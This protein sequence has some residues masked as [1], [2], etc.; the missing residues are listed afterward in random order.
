MKRHPALVPLSRQHHDALAVGVF[1]QRGLRDGAGPRTAERLR[2]QALDV[3]NLELSGHFEVEETVLFPVARE[4]VSQPETVD[5]LLREHDGI[6]EAFSA[7][8][9]AG[10]GELESRLRVLRE[11]LV[12]HIRFEE[13][14]VFEALQD[15]MAEQDLAELGLQIDAAL[16]RLCVRLGSA[17]AAPRAGR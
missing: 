13:R 7:L 10:S 16:P 4:A 5:R 11:R 3:W 6:R 14:V 2:R 15:S 1:I 9:H 17:A 12:A 8:E